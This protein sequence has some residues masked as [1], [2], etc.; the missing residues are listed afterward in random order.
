MTPD[1]QKI[2]DLLPATLPRLVIESDF[3]RR[4][5]ENII[6]A[7]KRKKLIWFNQTDGK[8]EQAQ[9]VVTL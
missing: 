2:Y 1:Q 7:L 4:K 3:G 6:E 9:K 5:V 8:Y